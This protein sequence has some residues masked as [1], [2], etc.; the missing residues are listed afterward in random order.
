MPDCSPRVFIIDVDDTPDL[1]LTPS[2]IVHTTT[3]VMEGGPSGSIERLEEKCRQLEF[4]N[5]RLRRTLRCVECKSRIAESQQLRTASASGV[6][7]R[8]RTLPRINP[9]DVNL[10]WLSMINE[11]VLE[12][13]Q[14]SQHAERGNDSISYDTFMRLS[15]S[16]LNTDGLQLSAAD[17]AWDDPLDMLVEVEH[18]PLR[19]QRVETAL[20][21]CIPLQISGALQCLSNLDLD[22]GFKSSHVLQKMDSYIQG[23]GLQIRDTVQDHRTL[24]SEVEALVSHGL[25]WIVREAWPSAEVFWKLT[26]SLNG[27]LQTEL[28]RLFPCRETY[29]KLHPA[30]RPTMLQL[31]VPHPPLV[32]WLPWPDLRD[33]IIRCQHQI[34]VEAACK[35]AIESVVAHQQ[36]GSALPTFRV[37]DLYL[38]EKQSGVGLINNQLSYKP[39]SARVISIEKAYGLVYD[40]FLSQRLHPDYFRKYP[41]LACDSIKTEF[42]V[43]DVQFTDYEGVGSPKPFT[44]M[45]MLQLKNVVTKRVHR[46]EA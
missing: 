6:L 3:L 27:F 21:A 9:G 28:W 14:S 18:S 46:R 8:Q 22:F 33:Q 13:S 44:E 5:R 15:D 24:T 41:M 43:R 10:D 37:W 4:E 2:I 40:D 36:G 11:E 16:D 12:V 38:L 17:I 42:S 25:C 31:T 29:Y 32:D 45:A 34:D 26:A 7:K 39:R 23:L 20:N 30:Y 35:A 1:L 19:Q